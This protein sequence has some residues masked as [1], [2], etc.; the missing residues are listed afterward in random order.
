MIKRMD[1]TC[2]R[3]LVRAA[4]TARWAVAHAST[5]LQYAPIVNTRA[6]TVQSSLAEQ[7]G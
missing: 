4:E 2:Y 5:L 7:V 6:Q 1:V 3:P